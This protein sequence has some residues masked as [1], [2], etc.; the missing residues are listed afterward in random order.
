[1]EHVPPETLVLL[2]LFLIPSLNRGHIEQRRMRR[3]RSFLGALPE[4]CA[5]LWA[6]CFDRLRPTYLPMHFLCTFMFFKQCSTEEVNASAAECDEAT[7]RDWVWHALS[8][9]STAEVAS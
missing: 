3:F 9:I 1:M 4:L 7:F 2:A 8:V 5:D 6:L